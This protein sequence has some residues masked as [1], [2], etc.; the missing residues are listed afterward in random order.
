ML[1]TALPFSPP[2]IRVLVL[3][4]GTPSTPIT[5]STTTVPLFSSPP[6]YYE[7]LSYVWGSPLDPEHISFN[8]HEGFPVTRNLFIALKYL[9]FPD[10]ERVLWVDAL[11][12]NQKDVSERN[13]QVRLMGEV[14]G[15][16]SE[17]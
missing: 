4:P 16:A 5:C 9:R 14:Y 17:V 7:A 2:H 11:C 1:Y 10:R 8:G 13:E 6:P 12:I 15:R 3:S